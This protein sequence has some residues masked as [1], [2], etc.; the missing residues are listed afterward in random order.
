MFSTPLISAGITVLTE[1]SFGFDGFGMRLPGF[2]VQTRSPGSKD[3][4]WREGFLSVFSVLLIS[5]FAALLQ[6]LIQKKLALPS[7][8]SPLLPQQK[9][10]SGCL[11]RPSASE[12]ALVEI[13]Q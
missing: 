6:P 9:I 4:V 11:Q 8:A 3:G 13:D 10:E 5:L 12:S 1:S 7:T 2:V